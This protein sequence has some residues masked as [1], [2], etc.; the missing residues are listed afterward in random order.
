MTSKSVATL[1][2]DLGVV[3]SHSQPKVSD[4]QSLLEAWFKTLKYAPVF[5]E[6]FTC[7][8]AGAGSSTSL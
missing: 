1:L 3:R 4:Q 7:L 6:R 5:P 2:S 8:A